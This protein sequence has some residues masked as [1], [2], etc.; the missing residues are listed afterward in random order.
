MPR[1]GNGTN[2]QGGV[3]S[4]SPRGHGVKNFQG[5]LIL[6]I[7]A[8]GLPVVSA[9]AAK[10]PDDPGGFNGHAWGTPLAQFPAFKLV[11]DLG[12]TDFVKDIGVYENPGE[13]LTLNEVR[14][15]TIRYRFVENQLES[16]LLQYT[17]R[18]NRDKLMQWLEERYGKLTSHER[19]MIGAILWYGDKTLI[20]LKY[21]VVTQQG[22]LYFLSQALSNRFNEVHQGTQGD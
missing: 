7:L 21:D 9:G 2:S 6:F 12:S 14:L 13:M 19:K 18:E 4:R 20:N 11:K 3:A 17:G 8:V 10:I 16:V 15:T 1:G 22:T 5:V